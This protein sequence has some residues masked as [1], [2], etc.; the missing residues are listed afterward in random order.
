MAQGSS[1]SARVLTD[2]DEIR[3]WAE[4]RGAEPACVIG[5]GGDG[6]IGMIRLDFPGYSGEG[7]LE[8]IDWDD[9]FQ[10]FDERNLALLVQDETARGERSNFNKLVSRETVEKE[11]AGRSSRSRSGSRSGSGRSRSTTRSRKSS[12]SRG[13]RTARAGAVR[14]S[15]ASSSSQRSGRTSSGRTGRTSSSSRSE[16][17]GTKT[18]SS[19][20]RSSRRK[21]A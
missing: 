12:A 11:Q 20:G 4:E 9:W 1:S 15:R 10:K 3:N 16:A 13:S 14:G 19:A 17:R 7:S 18:N 8:P 2:H 5:T 6:D 21:A